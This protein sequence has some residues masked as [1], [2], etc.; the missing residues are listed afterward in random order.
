MVAWMHVEQS[1][2]ETDILK[3]IDPASVSPKC[4]GN[5]CFFMVNLVRDIRQDSLPVTAALLLL[6]H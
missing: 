5:T 4:H 1:K 6:A 3:N 2:R